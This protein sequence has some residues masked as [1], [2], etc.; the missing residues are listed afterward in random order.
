VLEAAES[1][2]AQSENLQGAVDKFLVEVRA[3]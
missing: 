3:L 2:R 1:M